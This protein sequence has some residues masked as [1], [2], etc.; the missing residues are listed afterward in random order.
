MIGQKWIRRNELLSI[1]IEPN[2]NIRIYEELRGNLKLLRDNIRRYGN[3]IKYENDENNI[4]FDYVNYFTDN[5]IFMLDVYNELGRTYK[6]DAE[7]SKNLV[8]IYLKIYFPR[9][10][11][12]DFKYILDNLNGDTKVES[13][14]SV[15]IYETIT[16]DL[17]MENEIM[18]MVENIKTD[19]SYKKIFKDNLPEK[20]LH[21]EKILL[22]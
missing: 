20:Q 1:D 2:N 12:E 3:K 8:D 15:V 18:F 16:N 11:S 13:S 7:T 17:I 19:L 4:L 6:P 10:R 14:K 22:M 5:E 9:I 21:Y